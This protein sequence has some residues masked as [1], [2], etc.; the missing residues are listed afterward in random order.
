M[1]K[2]INILIKT[3]I[4]L[5]L[6]TFVA[7]NQTSIKKEVSNNTINKRNDLAIMALKV[8]ENNNNDIYHTINSYTGDLTGYIYNCPLCSGRLACNS[9]LDLSGGLTYYTDPTYGNVRIVA[10]STN[11][12]CGTIVRMYSERL[13]EEPIIAIVLDRGVRGNALDL[14]TE[15]MDAARIVGRSTINYDVLRIGYGTSES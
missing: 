4:L 6:V 3:S 7:Y 12:S 11:F 8:E 5:F 10:S 13:S 9:K 2:K 15:S 1:K 14:L